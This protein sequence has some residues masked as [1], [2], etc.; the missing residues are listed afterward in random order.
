MSFSKKNTT[1][2]YLEAAL[3]ILQSQPHI[4]SCFSFSNPSGWC[5]GR[6]GAG[7]WKPVAAGIWSGEWSLH[8]CASDIVHQLLD[9][10]E[11]DQLILRLK[12]FPVV[13]KRELA[14]MLSRAA[15]LS[16]KDRLRPTHP[17]SL[18]VGGMRLCDMFGSAGWYSRWSACIVWCLELGG[19]VEIDR[20]RSGK[21]G[22]GRRGL[23]RR[24]IRG[25][26]LTPPPWRRVDALE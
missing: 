20:F 12:A 6:H 16:G 5:R 11:D 18:G 8:C 1:V 14:F 21:A 13:M 2:Q 19:L 22:R 17:N 7:V 3:D 26:A 4:A 15:D 23:H 9:D 25:N 24:A 10:A